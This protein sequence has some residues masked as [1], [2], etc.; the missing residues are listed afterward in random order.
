[1]VKARNL[2]LH[3]NRRETM[4]PKN[5][6]G[7]KKQR[8]IEAAIRQGNEVSFEG[9][10]REQDEWTEDDMAEYERAYN[11]RTKKRRVKA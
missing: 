5:F 8:Q 2:W 11:K 3:R 9:K 4:K 10:P 6:Q 1:M 7:R